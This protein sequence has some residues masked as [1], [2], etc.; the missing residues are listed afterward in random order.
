MWPGFNPF[1]ST[2]PIVEKNDAWYKI[3]QE[4]NKKYKV[5]YWQFLRAVVIDAISL[6]IKDDEGYEMNKFVHCVHSY[7]IQICILFTQ[8]QAIISPQPFV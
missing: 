8:Y 6:I 2:Y 5:G 7:K 4:L 3:T 1:I